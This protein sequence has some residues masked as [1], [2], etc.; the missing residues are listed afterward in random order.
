[1]KKNKINGKSNGKIEAFNITV[2]TVIKIILKTFTAG[3]AGGAFFAPLTRILPLKTRQKTCQIKLKRYFGRTGTHFARLI[4][5][6][7]GDRA[8]PDR[9]F[10][11][12][13]HFSDSGNYIKSYQQSRKTNKLVLLKKLS[14]L[15]YQSG[16]NNVKISANTNKGLAF[17]DNKNQSNHN[18]SANNVKGLQRAN[19]YIHDFTSLNKEILTNQ[20]IKV[21]INPANIKS[22]LN[23]STSL[24]TGT[25]IEPKN[26]SP[27]LENI[28]ATPSTWR[29]L[30]LNKTPIDTVY[31]HPCD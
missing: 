29:D 26:S 18:Q 5:N 8:V 6:P 12:T 17:A 28:S 15:T 2:I 22:K 16:S 3:G 27:R 7:A 30:S 11:Q 19:N 25:I 24:N 10:P 23:F 4:N 21:N 20:Q 13:G 1:M 31:H 14:K 9:A